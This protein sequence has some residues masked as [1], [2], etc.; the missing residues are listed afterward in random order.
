M[1]AAVS[2][3]KLNQNQKRPVPP[4][5]AKP[6][7]ARSRAAQVDVQVIKITPKLAEDWLGKNSHNRPLRNKDVERFA[8][9]MERGEWMLNG[10]AIRFSAD[11]ETL[12]DGQHRLWAIIESGV[13]IDSV[14]AWGIEQAAQAT[15]DMG[16]RRNLKDVLALRGEP[17]ASR[18]A[19]AIS[20][21]WRRTQGLTRQPGAKPS[22]AQAIAL[23]EE[24]RGLRDAV[25]VAGKLLNRFHMSA[26]VAAV[27]YY[28]FVQID[29]EA[30]DV[31]YE[32]LSSG[33]GLV[34]GDPIL[35]LR[36]WLER[37][38]MV[39]SGARSNAITS[40]AMMIKA[41]NAAREGRHVEKLQWRPVG[42]PI[43]ADLVAVTRSITRKVVKWEP[44][45]QGYRRYREWALTRLGH[46][47]A[48][49]KAGDGW[50][51]EG[52]GIDQPIYVGGAY[53]EAQTNASAIVLRAESG[54]NGGADEGPQAAL[55][56]E[57]GPA[58]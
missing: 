43:E 15:M 16:A 51:L 27:A 42:I 49:Q 53:R 40:H 7:P 23:L 31:F 10:D 54:A 13:T 48:H 33:A 26:A 5:Q 12:L 20:L 44:V 11:G 58:V 22:P 2:T 32:K 34:E 57:V 45:S 14:V 50:Y 21:F 18:L 30:A 9:A 28:E 19:S 4:P 6:R 24:H 1:G 8:G 39:G 41:W 55:G 52:P 25:Q 3:T 47:G 17:Q 29:S 35:A 38:G 56:D 37:Q 36:R 46:A